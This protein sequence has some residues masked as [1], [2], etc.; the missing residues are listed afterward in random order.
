M[1]KKILISLIFIILGSFV[2]IKLDTILHI[3]HPFNENYYKNIHLPYDV[4]VLFL[5]TSR[6]GVTFHPLYIFKKY[7]V[8][9]YNLG[10]SS[11]SYKTT[12]SLLKKYKPR[13]AVIDVSVLTRFEIYRTRVDFVTLFDYYERI[14]IAKALFGYDSYKSEINTL[15]KYH[16]R[17]KELDNFDFK[18][19]EYDYTKGAWMNNYIFHAA[20]KEYKIN[21]SLKNYNFIIPRIQEIMDAAKS[22]NTKVIFF[23]PTNKMDD[24]AIIME[25]IKYADNNDI[26][27]IN[28]NDNKLITALNIDEKNDM[29]DFSHLNMYGSY[30]VMDHLMPILIDKFHIPDNRN[31]PKYISWNRDCLMYERNMNGL[32]IINQKEIDRWFAL[33]N[34]DNYTVILAANGD[35]LRKLPDNLKD[36]LK[37]YGLTKY[38]NKKENVRYAAIIDNNQVFYEEVSDKP[39]IYKGRMKNIFNLFLLSDGKATINI[40]GTPR[41][42]NKYGLN[43]VVYDKVNMAVVDSIWIDPNNPNQIKR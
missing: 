35:V 36:K 41:S 16:N 43:I 19:K 39:V 15:A 11:Q 3:K 29:F 25:F 23:I 37:S 14:H 26:D 24:R 42:K 4:D 34:Y 40:S 27:Y 13:F 9:S 12:L 38:D 1:L 32:E 7:G 17:W 30:K 31:N 21:E 2:L 8:V 33:S 18:S 10:T 22:S 20:N 5:G 28:Y 6:V